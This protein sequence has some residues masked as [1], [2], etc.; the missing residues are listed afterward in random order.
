VLRTEDFEAQSRFALIC[1][2]LRWHL[3]GDVAVPVRNTMAH[4][5]RELLDA[6]LPDTPSLDTVAAILDVH[7]V[8][9]VRAFSRE[10]GIPPHRY[11]TGRRL[12][13]ARRHLLAGVPAAE[14]AT[15]AGFYDQAHL[16]RHFTR[17]LGIGPARYALRSPL[18]RRSGRRL[19]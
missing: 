18:E 5:L 10:F 9:L 2:R 13:L 15:R 7:P 17:L 8:S 4:R 14:A 16:T 1:D 11:V 12:E 3:N 6:R 19:D